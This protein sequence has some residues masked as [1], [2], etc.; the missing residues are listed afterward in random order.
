MSKGFTKDNMHM[1]QGAD[2][3]QIERASEQFDPTSALEKLGI[4]LPEP[5]ELTDKVLEDENDGGGPIRT[6]SIAPDSQI[7]TKENIVSESDPYAADRAA[8]E[9]GDT[10]KGMRFNKGKLRYDL[11]PPEPIEELVKVYTMGAEKY[12]DRNWEKGLSV[13]ECF[14]SIMR[15]SFA[16]L[17]GQTKD[18]ES[19]LHHMGHVMWNAAAIVT[20]YYRKMEDDRVV[21]DEA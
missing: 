14:A 19:G 18:P 15:H 3:E 21:K 11:L 2:A 6:A 12:A 8:Y 7:F 10:S 13:M 5:L 20:F 9:A 4:T 16:W 17:R 1:M